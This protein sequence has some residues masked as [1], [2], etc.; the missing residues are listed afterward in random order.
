MGGMQGILF[1]FDVAAS[2]M[3]LEMQRAEIVAANVSNMAVTREADGKP[4]RRRALR[5][6]EA[7]ASRFTRALEGVMSTAGSSALLGGAKVTRISVD[8]KTPFPTYHDPGHPHA[9]AN[10]YVQMSNVDIFKEMV[11]MSVIQRSFDANIA[12]MQAYRGML[13]SALQNMR[14]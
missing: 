7:P 4:Y 2:G 3:R 5:I 1:G 11:D 10:G 9:D 12:T 14:S 8:D 6:E 13:Q